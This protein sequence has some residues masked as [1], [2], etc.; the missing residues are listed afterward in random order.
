MNM[1]RSLLV[2]ALLLLAGSVCTFAQ[3]SRGGMGAVPYADANGTGVTF[4]TWAPNASTVSVRG[5]FNGWG[6]TAMAADPSGGTW[7]VDVPRARAGDQYKFDVNGSQRKDP[8]GKRVVNSAGNSIVYD[9]NAFD[10]SGHSFGGIWRN[11]LVIYQMHVGTY[12][13]ESW[14]PSTFDQALEKLYYIKSMGFSAVKLMPV[15]E[16]PGDRSWGYNPSDPY[17]IESAFGGPDAL[18][19]FV[20]TC[21]ENGI[22]VL[23]DVVH[24]HYGPSDLE[25]WQYDGWSQNGLGGIYFYNDWKAHTDWGSTRPDFGRAEVRDYIQGQIRMFLE[26]YRVDGFRWDSVYNIRN[27]SGSWNQIG[28]D[29]LANINQ[30]M[31]NEFPNAFRIAEDHAFDTDIGFEAQWDHGFLNDIRWLATA[32]SDSDRNMDTLAHYLSNGGF[33]WVRYAESHDSCGDLNNKH[34]L[35]RDIDS[36]DPQGYWAKKRALLAHTIALISPGI[37]MIFAGS[38]MHEDWTFS[39][40]TALRWSL[41]NQNAGIVRAFADLIHLRRNFHGVSGALKEPGGI[42]VRHVNHGAKVVGVSRNNE[43][44]IVVNAS[45]TAWGTYDMAFPSA[46]TWYCLYNSDST[47]YDAGFGGIGPAVGGTVVADGSADATL[48]LGAYSMQI[49]AQTPIPQESAAAFDP[50]NPSGC[51]TTLAITYTP[52]DGPLEGA[53]A[54]SASIGRNDWQ[55]SVTVPMTADGDTWTLDYV[56]PDLTY[57]LNVTFTDGLDAWDNNGGLDWT[58]PV[59][60]CG[61]LPAEATW[62]PQVPQGCVPFEV[63]YHPNG[64]PLMGASN[65]TLFIGHN[66]WKNIVSLPMTQIGENEWTATHAIPDDTWELNFVFYTQTGPAEGDRTW[67]NNSFRNWRAL[68]SGCA[69]IDQPHVAITNPAPATSV[70]GTVA[71][72]DLEGTASLLTGHLRWTNQLNGASGQFAYSTNWQLPSVSLAEGVNVIRVSGTNSHVN[73]NHGAWDSPTNAAYASGWTDGSNGGALLQPWTITGTGAS[74]ADAATEGGT[75][76]LGSKAWALQADGSFVEAIRPFAGSL[77]AGDA[78]SFVFENGGIDGTPE[79]SVGFA[80][81]NRFGQRLI[82][83]YFYGGSTNWTLYDSAQ[84]DSGIG[85]DNAPK[86]CTFELLTSLDYRL[87][88]NGTV[89]EGEL[90]EASELLVSRIRFWNYNAGGGNDRKFYIGDLSIA[91]SPLPVFTSSS[92]I[93]VTRAASALRQTSSF[94]STGDALIATLSSISGIDGNVWIADAILDGD[95]NWTPL[96]QADYYIQNNTVVISPPPPGRLHV[97]SIGTPGGTP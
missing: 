13:A 42:Q 32:Q 90:P 52:G 79:A 81:E 73:P 40:N 44:M 39:N 72:V 69:S 36:G 54:V 95:W 16:F 5:G 63:T 2:A 61:D 82:E 8:R 37:P 50:P 67:D 92:E 45:A 75:L 14:L 31:I 9:P 49:Y 3:S 97:F 88:V 65:V 20:K 1:R 62:S 26:E 91:G 94:E 10:W 77:H 85:W 71:V 29:M 7:S 93:A 27:A 21:H 46:G 53:A 68:V 76:S 12:N 47:A 11:D 41:T 28:S 87:T 22:A 30:M 70:S 60:N 58:V 19:R 89:L 57:E 15:N 17:A 80:L 55:N 6:T 38:E 78:L 25:M 48:A 18:K 23:I 24:N 33:N 83:F 35:P 4:R 56:I 43:L 34:R 84:R 74:L 59:S 86:T 66:D 51:G 64:G 96:P